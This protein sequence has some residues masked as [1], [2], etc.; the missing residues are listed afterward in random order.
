LAFD[1]PAFV[2]KPGEI[3]SVE[4]MLPRRNGHRTPVILLN[5]NASDM[6]PLRQWPPDRYVELATR[7]L[8]Q[9]PEIHVIFTGAPNEAQETDQL[10]RKVNSTRCT[11]LAGKTTLRQL[12]VLYALSDILVTNDSGPA[13]FAALTPINVVTLFG[14]ETPAL[15]SAPSPR[16]LPMWAG[17]ACSPCV[18]AYNNRQS[19]CRDNQCMKQTRYFPKSAES[20][21]NEPAQ[22]PPESGFPKLTVNLFDK[23]EPS[24]HIAPE[25]PHCPCVRPR[26]S[27]NPIICSVIPPKS[28]HAGPRFIRRLV[29]P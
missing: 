26:A 12:M 3:E 25:K 6:L 20:T 5:P 2:P 29:A 15:F 24:L 11:C 23:V 7:L 13:H 19:T 16:N 18:N 21:R 9:W 1:F 27:V 28:A 22:R 14:P 10:A 8:A 17:L 4:V